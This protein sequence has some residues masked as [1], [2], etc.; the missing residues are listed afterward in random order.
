MTYTVGRIGLS[1]MA[2][3]F[4]AFATAKRPY[5]LENKTC[6]SARP[7]EPKAWMARYAWALAEIVGFSLLCQP[8]IILF[9]DRG[10]KNRH[11]PCINLTM[12]FGL[13]GEF[14]NGSRIALRLLAYDPSGATPKNGCWWG[15]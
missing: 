10:N 9:P 12:K 1:R 5:E 14:L 3:Q 11:A 2:D 15:S 13:R 8:H 4:A 6:R 7:A